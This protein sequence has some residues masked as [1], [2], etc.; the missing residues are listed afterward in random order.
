M[1][2]ISDIRVCGVSHPNGVA[3]GEATLSWQ[4]SVQGAGVFQKYYQIALKDEDKTVYS[5]GK[6]ESSR[7]TDISL[8]AACLAAGRV[9][10]VTVT[11]W[12][13]QGRVSSAASAFATAYGDLPSVFIRPAR[14]FLGGSVYFKRILNVSRPLR[15]ATLCAVAL[16]FGDFYLD[17]MPLTDHYFDGGFTNFEQ[18]VLWRTYDMTPYLTEGAHTLTVH[19]ADGFW[20]QTRVWAKGTRHGAKLPPYSDTPC[21]WAAAV[22]QYEDGSEE[23]VT[24]AGEGWLCAPGPVLTANV[25]A[26]EVYDARRELA[27]A[28]LPTSGPAWYAAVPDT[29]YKGALAPTVMP[30]CRLLEILP[31]V[32]VS[33]LAGRAEDMRFVYDFGRNLAGNVRLRMPPCPAGTQVTVRYAETVTESGEP[34][35]RSIGG[36]ATLNIQQDTYIAK[37]DPDGEVWEPAFSYKGF[38]YAEVTGLF[39]D[40]PRAEDAV[41][42]AISCDLP[43]YSRFAS[44]NTMLDRL[45]AV[46]LDTFRN[47]YHFFPEDCPAREKCGWLGDAQWCTDLWLLH[48]DSATAL[49]KYCGDIFD[50][51]E[52]YGMIPMIAPG[53]RH[54]GKGSVLWGLATVR[55]PYLL[56]KYAGM[57]SILERAYPYMREWMEDQVMSTR[58]LLPTE[59]LGD[60]LPPVG[61]GSPERTPV[62]HSSAIGLYDG[63]RMLA[64]IAERLGHPDEA[65]VWRDYAARLKNAFNRAYYNRETGSYGYDGTDAAAITLGL[66]PSPSRTFDA[67]CARLAERD[68]RMTTG[69]WGNAYL[70]PLLAKRGRTDL[71]LSVMFAP[72]HKNFR[73]ALEGGATSLPERLELSW[74]SEPK[75]SHVG[76]YD[77]PMH[78]AC[79][80]LVYTALLGIEPLEPGFASFSFSPA[81]Y[82]ELGGFSGE[83]STPCGRISVTVSERG[84]VDLTVPVGTKCHV[85]GNVLGPG[86]YHFSLE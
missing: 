60:W 7:H 86:D 58:G 37:G 30:P 22:L 71:M 19:A 79:M 66:A 44:G 50:S 65:M 48:F 26:G 75:G 41:A 29:A 36:I 25:Y 83:L 2:R 20:A 4:L 55:I 70:L 64:E 63:A 12:D 59:G 39:T 28:F 8:S 68:C 9:Y 56:W 10:E 49:V 54:C 51:Y 85:R 21:L 5:T 76:S 16:G 17:G 78:G 13:E 14:H 67:L 77:H 40:T 34:D 18:K 15:R 6:V 42:L 62:A 74:S 73:S 84:R 47:N 81:G 23:T 69:A 27:D 32:A 1:L 61:N 31:A 24:T 57:E 46:T 82:G 53:R 45:F 38:R 43:S 11:V 52:V 3:A 33:R 35:L 80:H 72:A